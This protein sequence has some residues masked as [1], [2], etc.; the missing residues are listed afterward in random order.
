MTPFTEIELVQVACQSLQINTSY[1]Y[2][3]N[4]SSGILIQQTLR[5]GLRAYYQTNK[6]TPPPPS[7]QLI[8]PITLPRFVFLYQYIVVELSVQFLCLLLTGRVLSSTRKPPVDFKKTSKDK[9]LND[10]NMIEM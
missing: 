5:S 9:G 3:T 1:F 6:P 10:K 2:K 4:R 7:P 8:S